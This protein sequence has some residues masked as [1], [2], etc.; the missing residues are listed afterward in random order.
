VRY[1]LDVPTGAV[2]GETS[3]RSLA[4]TENYEGF[5]RRKK[6]EI[7]LDEIKEEL[8]KHHGLGMDVSTK[9]AKAE[10]LERI[11][12]PVFQG[13][14]R[15]WPRVESFKLEDI[16]TVRDELWKITRG[17]KYGEQPPAAEPANDVLQPGAND[18]PKTEA[19]A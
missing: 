1:L 2:A 18:P 5:D 19:A 16:L 15:S 6:I 17:H 4:P 8:G 11:T 3:N 12:K 7:A 14:T 9:T 13:G 10:T